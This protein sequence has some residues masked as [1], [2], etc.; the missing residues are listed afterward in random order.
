MNKIYKTVLGT[1]AAV[2]VAGATMIPM[3]VLAWNDSDGGRPS[4]TIEQIKQGKLGDT[5]TFNSISDSKIGDEKNFVGAKDVTST[6][7]IWS[8]DT[9]DVKD[10]GTYT[11]RLY[12]HNNSPLGKEKIAENVTANFSIPTSVGKELTIVGYLNST[13]AK[14]TR[15]WDEVTFRASEDIY[16]EYVDGSAEY[17]N[18]KMGTVKLPNEVIT[19]G[20]KLGYES[21]D[22]K[23]PGCYEYDG[24]VTIKVKVHK[25]VNAKLSK[26]VRIKG[27]K[28]W[29]ESVNAKIGDEVEFQIEYEN[30]LNESVENVMIRDVLPNNLEYVAGS[31]YLY[32]AKYP[33]GDHVKDDTVTTTGINI[34][35]YATKGNA[36]VR[37]TAKVVNNSLVCGSNQL[38]NWASSTV[39]S[40]V[41]KDDAS[42]FVVRDNCEPEPTPTPTP[43]PEPTPTPKV[44]PD[45]GP[46]EV[47]AIALGAG[48]L[49]TVTGYYVASRKKLM[50]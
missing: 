9:I 47:V 48:T 26:T 3:P 2:I 35:G 10:G 11:V 22:G 20:A 41:S 23:I 17:T 4:Y 40:K 7:S 29:S 33:K 25:S 36:F 5:I 43:T 32:N 31:T 38:V 13:N 12:V 27:T 1:A 18:A 45:T 19:S 46:T 28:E 37:F 6:S 24:V 39:N 14:P 44:I 42:V 21:L 15:Y 49:T 16:L 50:K 30:W 34:G 8:A